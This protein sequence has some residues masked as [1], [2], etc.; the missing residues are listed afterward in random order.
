MNLAEVNSA[1]WG[2]VVGTILQAA[3]VNYGMMIFARV[4]NGIFN[5]MLTSTVPT[6][7]SECCKPHRRGQL[8]LF[9]GSLITLV[10]PFV[11]V[12]GKV[13]DRA[14]YH[15]FVLD[16]SRFFLHRWSDQLEVPGCVPVYFHF[17]YVSRALVPFRHRET[18]TKCRVAAMWWFKV[19]E[20]P[21]WLASKG[22]HAEALAVLAALDG[23]TVH[24]PEVLKT[25]RGIVDAI[26]HS[27]SDFEIKQLFTHGKSQHFR[28]TVLG[29]GAQL[30]QQISGIK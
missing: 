28:R 14:G 11:I 30:F 25:W 5:G 26:S 9:S 15:G 6:Y 17:C 23:T 19:P 13:S 22:R 2:I 27:A 18:D 12:P 4:F 3:S 10:R 7:Q 16:R 29:C 21:R 20:S 24:D 1:A 8:L